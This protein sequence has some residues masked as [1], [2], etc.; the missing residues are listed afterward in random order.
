MTQMNPD[1][2]RLVMPPVG[3][4]DAHELNRLTH[5]IIGKAYRFGSSLG[6]GFYEKVY[7][8][9]LVHELRKA[10]LQVAPQARISVWYDGI[11]V[12]DYVPDILVERAV[13]IEIKAVRGLDPAHEAQCMN[14]LAATKAPLCLLFNFRERV[15]VRRFVGKDA[16]K[17]PALNLGQSGSSVAV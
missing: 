11:V 6:A 17:F 15:D 12:G 13:L 9:A 16:P 4:W 5:A 8:N 1:S 3:G 7:E 2:D 14:C 10:G